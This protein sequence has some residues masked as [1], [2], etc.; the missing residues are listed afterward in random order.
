MSDSYNA[1]RLHEHS[2]IARPE[3]FK[4]FTGPLG[5]AGRA[6]V[7]YAAPA[8]TAVFLVAT[9]FA[10]AFLVATFFAAG[11]FSGAFFSVTFFFAIIPLVGGYC[12]LDTWCS[13]SAEI[14]V[15]RHIIENNS[16]K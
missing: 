3:G 15:W 8:F 1:N 6:F 2:R 13:P 9:F 12:P 16:M 7:V 11:F 10:V 4:P 14:P 5:F